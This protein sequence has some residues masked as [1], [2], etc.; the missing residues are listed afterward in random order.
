MIVD[1]RAG[2]ERGEVILFENGMLHV[3]RDE[4]THEWIEVD[5]VEAVKQLLCGNSTQ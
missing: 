4:G 2:T 3:Q 1:E 5:E